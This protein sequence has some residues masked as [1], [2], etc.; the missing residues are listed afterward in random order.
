MNQ[1]TRKTHDVLSDG[2]DVALSRR[3]AVGSAGAGILSILCGSTLGQGDPGSQAGRDTEERRRL[4]QMMRESREAA[5]KEKFAK[6]D[7]QE[8]AFWEGIQNAG[9]MEERQKV[10]QNWHT[11][12][13]QVTLNSEL[14]ASA[15]EWTVIQPKLLA[16]LL[17]KDAPYGVGGTPAALLVAQLINELRVLVSNKETKPEEIKAKLTALRSAKVQARQELSQA[18]KSLRQLMTLRQEAVLVLNGLLE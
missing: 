2:M 8:R 12:Q 3:V 4:K 9:S 14:G 11:Q 17:L 10:L 15:E 1:Q 13:M 18:Q 6:M 5:E 16:V 7:P